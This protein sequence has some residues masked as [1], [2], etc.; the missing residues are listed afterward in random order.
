M[1]P[2]GKFVRV[3][4]LVQTH[5]DE[6][7]IR[8]P[9]ALY[10]DFETHALAPEVTGGPDK[11]KKALTFAGRLAADLVRWIR[12]SM[13]FRA[14]LRQTRENSFD[15]LIRRI[16][17]KAVE[18]VCEM[19]SCKIWGVRTPASSATSPIDE[20]LNLPAGEDTALGT[21]R[22]QLVTASRYQMIPALSIRFLRAR[23]SQSVSQSFAPRKSNPDH[24]AITN[25]VYFEG[26]DYRAPQPAQARITGTIRDGSTGADVDGVI[27]VIRM[28]GRIPVKVSEIPAPGGHFDITVPA[29]ARLRARAPGFAAELKSVFMDY[30][31]L[32]DSM[33]SMTPEGISDWATYEKIRRDLEKVRLDFAL[34]RK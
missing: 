21:F 9:L 2:L 11:L 5:D 25:P 10:R 3:E 30:A 16:Q 31:P 24:V 28:D 29:T 8:L 23:F 32:L 26:P 6:T 33:L 19:H 14:N 34:G 7:F 1:V 18:I 4:G 22:A 12:T 20:R 13:E 15:L 27:E 17:F